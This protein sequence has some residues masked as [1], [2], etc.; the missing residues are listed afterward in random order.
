[1]IYLNDYERGGMWVNKHHIVTIFQQI[2]DCR[3]TFING[4]SYSV[5]ETASEVLQKIH[6]NDL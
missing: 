5:I 1:M 2:R 3:I 6:D 4:D